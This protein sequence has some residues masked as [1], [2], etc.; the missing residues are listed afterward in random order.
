MPDAMV[1]C[2]TFSDT[3]CLWTATVFVR[4]FLNVTD[5]IVFIMHQYLARPGRTFNY[6]GGE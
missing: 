5:N 2:N 6:G 1:P 4:P 3:D